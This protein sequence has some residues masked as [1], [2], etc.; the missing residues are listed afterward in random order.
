M[1]ALKTAS[2]FLSIF[3]CAYSF[4]QEKVLKPKELTSIPE[5]NLIKCEQLSFLANEDYDYY[6]AMGPEDKALV[7]LGEKDPVLGHFYS[8]ACSWYCGGEISS[9]SSSSALSAQYK[10]ENAHDFSI[11]NVW[12]EGVPGNGEGEYL[13]Y[14]FPGRCPRITTIQ[15]LNGYIKTEKAWLDN[16]RV[17]RLRMYY[18]GEPYAILELED[19]RRLQS[20][21]VGILGFH[22]TSAP[23]WTLKFEILD[24]YPGDKY[25]D[26]IIT[27][28][29]FDGIDVH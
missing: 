9:V 7:D 5:V 8:A 27:E 10:G 16:G 2:I 21:D 28:L 25:A 1:I 24:V 26:T 14:T 6:K 19:T 17:K 18:N 15:I 13:V 29:Y 20:F 22:D 4:A 23:N 3:V 12:A 11:L